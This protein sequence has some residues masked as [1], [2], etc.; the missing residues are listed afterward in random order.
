LRGGVGGAGQSEG[1]AAD[2]AGRYDDQCDVDD[3]GHF[4]NPSF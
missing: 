3:G 4:F 2:D 1:G